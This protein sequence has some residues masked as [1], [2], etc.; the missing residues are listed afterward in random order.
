[1]VM[2]INAIGGVLIDLF[3]VEAAAGLALLAIVFGVLAHGLFDQHHRDGK[4]PH[5]RSHR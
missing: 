2:E 1:M 3:E 4:R 5:G